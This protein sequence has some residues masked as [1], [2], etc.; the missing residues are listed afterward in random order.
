MSESSAKDGNLLVA[1]VP[2]LASVVAQGLSSL[3]G[4]IAASMPE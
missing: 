1:Q 3:D 2:D 4:R